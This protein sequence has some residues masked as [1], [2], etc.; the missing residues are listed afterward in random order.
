MR[1]VCD[2]IFRVVMMRGREMDRV[3]WKDSVVRGDW[4]RG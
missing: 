4:Y 3:E 2:V 1:E